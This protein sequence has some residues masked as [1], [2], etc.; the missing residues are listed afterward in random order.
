MS[1]SYEPSPA[2]PDGTIPGDEINGLGIAGFVVSIVGMIIT[3][4]LLCPIGLLISL[5]AMFKKPRGFAV[6]GAVLGALGTLWLVFWGFAIVAGIMGLQ[7]TA[8]QF[9]TVAITTT[10]LVEGHQIIESRR[11]A[12]NQLPDGI[13]GNKLIVDLADGWGNGIRYEVEDQSYVL[14][15]GGPDG[16]FDTE[17]DITID[18]GGRVSEIPGEHFFEVEDF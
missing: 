7:K 14:R 12:D 5:F 18:S 8:T 6:A 13:E 2:H 11:A 3:C 4:G 15:S 17:D 16:A 1:S 10:K 9:K